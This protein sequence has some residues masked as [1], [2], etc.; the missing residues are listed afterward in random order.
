[1]YG[2]GFYKNN[3]ISFETLQYVSD[4]KEVLKVANGIMKKIGGAPLT[5][6]DLYS[7]E[8]VSK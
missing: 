6:E 4:P 8:A 5:E 7:T 2:D 1:V 3:Y